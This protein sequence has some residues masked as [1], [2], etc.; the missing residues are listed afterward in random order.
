MKHT[1]VGIVAH[2]DAGK[3]TLS[4]GLLY[5]SG[6]LRKLGRV[7]HQDT[8]L[9]TFSLEKAR[10]ITIFS[11]EAR[12]QWNDLKMT[13]LD[14]PGHVD[15]STEM[16]R[17]LQ[18]LD[19][20][21]LVVNGADG[22]QGHTRTLWKL[23][24]HYRI[25]TFIFVNKMDIAV[26]SKDEM[27][28][29]MQ[30][31]LSGNCI[32]F[33][34]AAHGTDTFYD[35]V[36]MCHEELLNAFLEQG[37]VS[38]LLLQKHIAALHVYPCYFGS[39]LKLDGLEAFLDALEQYSKMPE[40]SEE[41]GARVYKITRDKQNMRVTHMKITGGSLR[42]KDTL[43]G[44]DKNQSEVWN[45]KVNQ[46]RLYD[47]DKFETTDVVAAGEICAVT[48]LTKTFPG[49]GL[50]VEKV[51]QLPVLQPVL[52]YRVVFLDDVNPSAAFTQLRTLEE[53]DPQ[54]QVVWNSELAE[55]HMQLM[56]E[57]QIDILTAIIKERWGYEIT[58]D[59]GGILY[60]ETIADTVEGVGHFEP[61]RHYA[62]VHLCMEPGEAGSGM[63][64]DIDC[65]ED[66]LDKNW[67]KLIYTH[68]QEKQHRGV[69]IGAPLTDVKLTLVSGKA[70]NK[71][72]EGGDFREA[73]Y[74]AI[75]Q[76]LKYAKSTILEPYYNFQIRLPISCV[77]RAMQDIEKMFGKYEMPD[78]MDDFAFIKGKAPVSTMQGYLRELQS[79][80]K[81]LGTLQC[82]VAGYFP[83]HNAEEVETA[84]AYDSEGDLENPTGSVF[85]SH[86]S[87]YLVPWNQ[88]YMY[89][90]LPLEQ[91]KKQVEEIPIQV[92]REK[93]PT[94]ADEQALKEIWLREF[95]DEKKRFDDYGNVYYREE[96]RKTISIPKEPSP[97]DAKYLSK[98][99][100]KTQ[101]EYLL[102]DGYNV[103]FA[104]EELKELSKISL[105]AARGKLLD[106]MCNYQGY[107]GISVIVVFDAYKVK[108]N[109]GS[110]EQYHNIDVIY[111]K[112]AETAD[113]YIEK[114]THKIG[115]KNK[116]TVA[117]SDGLEQTIVMQQ[118]A[119]RMSALELQQRVKRIEEDM[120]SFVWKET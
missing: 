44:L 87:G 24:I 27:M 35:S 31:Q 61:L 59:E 119:L 4:E 7:D 104:W 73:T 69:R 17:T 43:T 13:F 62:E 19:Y 29:Q 91:E 57:V 89:M 53:E 112:E 90:H 30:E 42:I 116:V 110:V 79:Y 88:V 15:F 77:G 81:G 56:G 108:G 68:M 11:K 20:A 97:I 83:C 14:T 50:G 67:Q 5:T 6:M 46:I 92:T 25:P 111:T 102:V 100:T 107:C 9:D 98:K 85:C 22:I 70:H 1:V 101:K 10:G 93:I 34:E 8:F 36:A 26:Q 28:Q 49:Q 63:Q 41:F 118:G 66:L 23:L 21:I 95:G 120:Q 84:I 113:M 103:I 115:K 18:V 32:D 33:T 76:G 72:T 86:G 51:Q 37:S 105:D 65:S 58:F 99:K 82:E 78:M 40:Y 117:S 16:E 47:G 80:S 74:R 54:L 2:V 3:T 71:H 64:Y 94:E 96:D 75:R 60:K 38:D 114:V 39:A 106:I 45:E 48:G 12:L 52:R 109:P 55:V